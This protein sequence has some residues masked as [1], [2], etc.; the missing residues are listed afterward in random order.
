MYSKWG[1]S[2][3][4]LWFCADSDGGRLG[5]KWNPVEEGDDTCYTPC[6][7]WKL[8][9]LVAPRGGGYQGGERETKQMQVR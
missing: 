7:S 9:S 1:I 4:Y 8:E 3:V 6:Q 5:A 2:E